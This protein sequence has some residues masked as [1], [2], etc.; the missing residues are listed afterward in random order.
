M[1]VRGQVPGISL[2]RRRGDAVQCLSVTIPTRRPDMSIRFQVDRAGGFYVC[3]LVGIF[4]ESDIRA[5]YSTFYT[6]PDFDARHDRLIDLSDADI[7]GIPE[8]AFDV[9]ARR[10][11]DVM[12]S[13]GREG[14]R[15]AFVVPDDGNY[16]QVM[17]YERF[18][19]PMLETVRLFRDM[20]S[21]RRWLTGG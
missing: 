12:L 14:L 13:H 21:A 10:A 11:A 1:A 3:T 18:A 4:A 5:A 9:M 7:T 6:T 8:P 17:H 16:A 15:T 20:A 19:R 2:G